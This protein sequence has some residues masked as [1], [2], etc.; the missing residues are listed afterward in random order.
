[1]KYT[2]QQLTLLVFLMK[3]QVCMIKSE[4]D[5]FSLLFEFMKETD[6]AFIP[7]NF[8]ITQFRNDYI[9]L[10]VKKLTRE[11]FDQVLY[12]INKMA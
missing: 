1:M 2:T 3:L 12:L 5:S 11:N 9:P 8:F 7:D 6:V 4:S 10:V